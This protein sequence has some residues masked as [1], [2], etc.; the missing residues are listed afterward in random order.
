SV[1]EIV[2]TSSVCRPSQE[3]NRVYVR[4]HTQNVHPDCEMGN[5]KSYSSIAHLGYFEVNKT[6]T[7]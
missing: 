7:C 4:R 3:R 1:I 5:D 6:Y 2:G